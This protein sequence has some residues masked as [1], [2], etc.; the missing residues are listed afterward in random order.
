MLD[1]YFAIKVVSR[2]RS[3]DRSWR[4]FRNFPLPSEGFSIGLPACE[5]LPTFDNDITIGRVQFHQNACRPV[6]CAAIKE[7]PLPPN[8]YNTFS[9]AREEYC[10]TDDNRMPVEKGTISENMTLS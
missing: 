8:R 1:G 7:E 2:R 9:P 4:G 10:M 5:L 3:H 6:C